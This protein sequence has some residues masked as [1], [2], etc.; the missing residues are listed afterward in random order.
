MC[1]GGPDDPAFNAGCLDLNI[2]RRLLPMNR[3]LQVV[4]FGVRWAIHPLAKDAQKMSAMNNNGLRVGRLKFS[5]C[6]YEMTYLLST[7]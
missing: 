3:M 6:I 1:T 4:S 7:K 2:Y 5:G